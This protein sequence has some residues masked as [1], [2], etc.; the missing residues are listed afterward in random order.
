MMKSD[1]LELCIS[2]VDKRLGNFGHIEWRKG[3]AACVVMASRG[4]PG[5]YS[6]GQRINGLQTGWPPNMHVFH[7][8]TRREGNNWMTSGGR[9]LCA[10]AAENDLKTALR[11]GASHEV[12]KGL[13]AKAVA[14]KPEKHHLDKTGKASKKRRMAQIGG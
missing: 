1:L 6:T 5:K 11:Q 4:Y 14:A 7:S 3:S 9:V 12:L 13:L 8:G 10:M 2:V